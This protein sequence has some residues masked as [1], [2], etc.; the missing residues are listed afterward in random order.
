VVAEEDWITEVIPNPVI[1]P[2][3]GF[4][5]IAAS[6]PLNFS[7]AAFCKPELIIFIPSR[8]IPNAP[9]NVKICNIPI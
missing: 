9:S 7:P 1:T 5:V 2:L 8:N 4:D 6:R 3:N